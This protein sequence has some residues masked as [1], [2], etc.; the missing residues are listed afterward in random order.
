MS[1]DA[2]GA[3]VAA[4]SLAYSSQLIAVPTGESGS[5]T[6]NL[7]WKVSPRPAPISYSSDNRFPRYQR[8]SLFARNNPTCSELAIQ[9]RGTNAPS[10]QYV[11]PPVTHNLYF[12][13][14]T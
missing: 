8:Y 4:L 10:R 13:T 7:R 9:S 6:A 12:V 14:E 5:R 3:A 1:V 2:L 11:I